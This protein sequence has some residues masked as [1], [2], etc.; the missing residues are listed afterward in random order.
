MSS[1]TQAIPGTNMREILA[2]VKISEVYY[3]LTGKEPRRVGSDAWR[4]A[5][6]W[7]GGDGANVSLND[8]RNVWYDF[9]ANEG[10]EFW[11]SSFASGV[12]LAKMRCDG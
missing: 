5:A 1:L 8:T 2:R 10:A 4:G 11:T 6:V 9:A 3:T 12:A 7:R